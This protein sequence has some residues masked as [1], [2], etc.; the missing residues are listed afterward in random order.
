MAISREV[1]RTPVGRITARDRV[2]ITP[3]IQ[4]MYV[5]IG[6]SARE[7]ATHFGIAKSTVHRTITDDDRLEHN[8]RKLKSYALQCDAM[9]EEW[10]SGEFSFYTFVDRWRFGRVNA[11]QVLRSRGRNIRDMQHR[12]RRLC[13]LH[14][15][16]H[17]YKALSEKY[18]IAEAYAR[19]IVV[20]KVGATKRICRGCGVS[21]PITAPHMKYCNSH[22]RLTNGGAVRPCAICGEP[23]AALKTSIA[24]CS[25]SCG[26]TLRK[27]RKLRKN[28]AAREMRRQ[29]KKRREIA[30]KLGISEST[31]SHICSGGGGYTHLPAVETILR[32]GG[33]KWLS[34]LA[35]LELRRAWA[36]LKA[37]GLDRYIRIHCCS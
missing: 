24:T 12:D 32:H 10:E 27:M 17:S 28:L 16:G 11:S 4:R 3:Q 35:Q 19:Q 14:G 13:E 6:Y 36:A 25:K 7:I 26:Q 20:E 22:C 37:E 23:V 18:Q 1:E 8:R 5:L 21:F 29:G 2:R 31:A 9:I 33:K 34:G 30:D 15:E